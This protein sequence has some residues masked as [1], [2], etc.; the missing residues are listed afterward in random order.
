MRGI[1]KCNKMGLKVKN[2]IARIFERGAFPNHQFT[3]MI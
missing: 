1:Q 2:V 3:S